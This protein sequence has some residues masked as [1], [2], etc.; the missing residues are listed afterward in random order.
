[1]SEEGGSDTHSY[2]LD[3]CH[4]LG[5]LARLCLADPQQ[6]VATP[7]LHLHTDVHLATK[8]YCEKA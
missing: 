3:S 7:S 1:V 4:L 5:T 2:G 6:R 8:R